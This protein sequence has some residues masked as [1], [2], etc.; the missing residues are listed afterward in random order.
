LKPYEEAV[1]RRIVKKR[2]LLTALEMAKRLYNK[3][4][5]FSECADCF[6]DDGRCPFREHICLDIDTVISNLQLVLD[7]K[8]AGK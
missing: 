7:E 1:K 3:L 6:G 5:E 8:E 4:R 2:D